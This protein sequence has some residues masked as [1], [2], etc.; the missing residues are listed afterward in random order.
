MKHSHAKLSAPVLAT[1]T[2]RALVVDDERTIRTAVA[3]YLRRRG[4]H[5][6]EAEDGRAAL[7]KLERALPGAYH[8]VISDLRM[9]H[10]SGDQLHDWLEQH[11][12]DL[13]V[14]LILTTGDLTSP[15]LSDFIAR[16]P[17]PVIEK[18]F[19]LADLAQLVEAVLEGR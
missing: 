13:F 15:A 18:P 9:P 5:A 2:R 12:P 14:C 10:Y 1:G 7:L 19:E 17:R 3:R 4:W 8:V 6:E 11:R 16:T